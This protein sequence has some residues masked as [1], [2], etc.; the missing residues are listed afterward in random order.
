MF[1]PL[2]EGNFFLD[3]VQKHRCFEDNQTTYRMYYT[4]EDYEYFTE[5]FFKA[6]VPLL[7]ILLL[8]AMGIVIFYFA[9]EAYTK[10]NPAYAIYDGG[11]D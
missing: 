10:K 6:Y 1:T 3:I 7:L 5:H 2:C 11:C 9:R 4:I 8:S